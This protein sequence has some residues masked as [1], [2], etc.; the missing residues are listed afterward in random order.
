[1]FT[2]F[3]CP[4]ESSENRTTSRN[5]LNFGLIGW[6]NLPMAHKAPARGTLPVTVA[7][8]QQTS[9]ADRTACQRCNEREWPTRGA[10]RALPI[11]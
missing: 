11:I 9:S 1:V 6:T 2:L 4:L 7:A 3:I 5:G 10:Y 8:S